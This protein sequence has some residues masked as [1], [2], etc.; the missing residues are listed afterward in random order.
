M[1]LWKIYNSFVP[2]FQQHL[3]IMRSTRE[4]LTSETNFVELQKFNILSWMW[5]RYSFALSPSIIGMARDVRRK[6]N[7]VSWSHDRMFMFF[8]AT[9]LG[10]CSSHTFQKKVSY[11]QR[12]GCIEDGSAMHLCWT[13]GPLHRQ[14]LIL[15]NAKAQ[16]FWDLY[17]SP[18]KSASSN[19]LT[20]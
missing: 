20:M 10:E 4:L 15:A 14:K 12:P 17:T 18:S 13:I 16:P 19:L 7:V 3:N 6:G 5:P 8:V 11:W 9:G 1:S 2:S